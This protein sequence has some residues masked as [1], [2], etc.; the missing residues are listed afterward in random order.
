MDDDS[1]SDLS[2][3]DLDE[4]TVRQRILQRKAKAEADK[5]P[6]VLRSP[7]CAVLGHVDT[8]KVGVEGDDAMPPWAYGGV[9][10]LGL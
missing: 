10:C 6:S 4:A 9:A 8:G 3:D 5:D 1:E 7:I 2:D